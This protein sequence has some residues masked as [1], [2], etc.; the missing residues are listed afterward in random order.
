MFNKHS[1]L[2]YLYLTVY[3]YQVCS[4]IILVSALAPKSPLLLFHIFHFLQIFKTF[5]F[6][7]FCPKWA[8][9]RRHMCLERFAL[10]SVET[11]LQKHRS[12]FHTISCSVVF[13]DF[14]V[15]SIETFSCWSLIQEEPTRRDAARVKEEVLRGR[16]GGRRWKT[17][18]CIRGICLTIMKCRQRLIL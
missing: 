6:F 9:S 11:W 15:S 16:E 3:Q 14:K 13:S 1:Y 5:V 18:C 7:M 2:I 17:C 4:S 10:I 12:T 8:T